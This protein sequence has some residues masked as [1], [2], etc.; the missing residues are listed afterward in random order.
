[1]FLIWV[2]CVGGL[3]GHRQT[4]QCGTAFPKEEVLCQCGDLSFTEMSEAVLTRKRQ[5]LR[6]KFAYSPNHGTC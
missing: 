6:E 1:M 4:I 3:R 2:V 5:L